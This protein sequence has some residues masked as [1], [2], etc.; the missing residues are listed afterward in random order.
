M[1]QPFDLIYIDPPWPFDT[2]SERGKGKSPERHYNTLSIKDLC[3]LPVG[4]LV[5]P[6][7]VM[8]L[9]ATWPRLLAAFQVIHAWGFEYKTSGFVWAK[10]N[11]KSQGFFMG[12]G[13]YTR[14]NTEPC[15]LAVKTGGRAPVANRGV[16]ELIVAP[17]AKHSQKPVEAYDRIEALYPQARKVEV[18]ARTRRVGWWAL[19]NEVN[20]GMDIRESLPKVLRG[21]PVPGFAQARPQGIRRFVFDY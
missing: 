13:Y 18:F 6:N 1:D 3:A 11:K 14:A 17:V 15:L 19:G 7:G 2:Y 21:E 10:T 4:E 12:T 16:K 9:W 20:E 8:F 5:G